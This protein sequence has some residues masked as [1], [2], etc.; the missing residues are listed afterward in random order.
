MLFAV[1]A[2][3]MMVSCKDKCSSIPYTNVIPADASIVVSFDLKATW[4]KAGLNG[5][6]NE[7]VKNKLAGVLKEGIS[8][9]SFDLLEKIVEN[10]AESGIDIE[11]PCYAF[12]QKTDDVWGMAV[13]VGNENKLKV[14]LGV[15]VSEGIV[16][17]VE[18]R[19]GYSYVRF[20][21]SCTVCAFNENVV[22]VTHSSNNHYTGTG[23]LML[24]KEENSI[25]VSPVFRNMLTQKGEIKLMITLKEL[26][27]DAFFT[28]D[29]WK[30]VA[31]L[32]NLSFENGKISLQVESY[33]KSEKLQTW[34]ETCKSQEL[35]FIE[36]FPVSTL[37]YL[38]LH[39]DGEKLVDFIREQEEMYDSFLSFADVEILK[40]YEEFIRFID[41]DL[42]V[43]LLDVSIHSSFAA[44]AKVK[45]SRLALQAFY[46]VMD[47]SGGEEIITSTGNDTYVYKLNGQSIYFGVKNKQLYVTNDKKTAENI[48]QKMNGKSLKDAE[49]AGNMKETSSY[50]VV[51]VENLFNLPIVKFLAS[52]RGG[53][54]YSASMDVAS[55]ISY[56]E[57]TGK[58]SKGEINL[59]FKDKET[60]ALKQIANILKQ[61]SGL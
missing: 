14:L 23:S 43:G 8:R 49:F 3:T 26:F 5:K 31:V 17:P 10:P 52:G 4:D 15:M 61:H 30:E 38:S 24:Q 40:T 9:E 12:T 16:T 53:G 59:C 48:T 51:N 42:S 13:K 2:A 58:G 55:G 45:D 21:N 44:Y 46:N 50:M 18:K 22:L 57:I 29:E 27:P 39:L 28:S 6:E 33:I 20:E 60:N 25:S 36:K 19:N 1:F 41:G 32:S 47:S 37:V 7:E 56:L 35:S 54:V 11:A 34:L